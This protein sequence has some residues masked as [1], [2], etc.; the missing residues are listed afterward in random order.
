MMN[1]KYLRTKNN[2]YLPKFPLL[3]VVFLFLDMMALTSL[4]DFIF[5][6]GHFLFFGGEPGASDYQ[7]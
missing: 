1:K 4:I 2:F 6:F 5:L 3:P 7:F